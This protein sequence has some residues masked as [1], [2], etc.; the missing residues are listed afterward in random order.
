[1][2]K[3]CVESVDCLFY[4]TMWPMNVVLGLHF[5]WSALGNTSK[6]DGCVCVM[7]WEVLSW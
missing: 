5:V 2:C 1:M 7:G 4:M 3:S 6:G